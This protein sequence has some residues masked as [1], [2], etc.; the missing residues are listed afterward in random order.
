MVNQEQRKDNDA[1]RSLH[2]GD[3][4]DRFE[5]SQPTFRIERL[6][7]YIKLTPNLS[8]VDFACGN[9]MLLP[10]VY[11]KVASYHGVDFS[12]DFIRR[13][14]T[15]SNA[16][17]I[18]NA[19]FSCKDINDFCQENPETFDVG[20]A[21]DFFEHVYDDDLSVILRHIFSSLKPGSRFYVHTPNARFFLEIAK[22]Y[23]FL[24]RQFPEH[25]AVR[26][27]EQTT[28]LLRDAGFV[29]EQ[30]HFVSHYNILRLLHPLSFVPFLG[31]FF[32]A[33]LFI[34][35]RKPA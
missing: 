33:R 16:L 25:I 20:F 29:I 9:A 6:L 22:N 3:Y 13:C 14:T 17:G 8:I 31:N 19:A 28:K 30:S 10:F 27:L 21:L 1:L 15:K 26:N 23:N 2:S 24:V 5:N 35:A 18:R 7:Q 4:V 12:E 11:D 34:V 32:K